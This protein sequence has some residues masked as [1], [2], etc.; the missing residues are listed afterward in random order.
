MLIVVSQSVARLEIV[1]DQ[2]QKSSVLNRIARERGEDWVNSRYSVTASGE[3]VH[4]RG[5]ATPATHSEQNKPNK[6]SRSLLTFLFGSQFGFSPRFS[7]SI[8]SA[9]SEVP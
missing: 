9:L 6:L 3:F 2:W 7:L 4:N 1:P 5:G 8:S